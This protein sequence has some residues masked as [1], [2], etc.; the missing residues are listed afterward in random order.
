MLFKKRIKKNSSNHKTPPLLPQNIKSRKTNCYLCTG[1]KI[2]HKQ[3]T[4]NNSGVIIW[5]ESFLRLMGGI[6]VFT[7][8]GTMCSIVSTTAYEQN[9]R[10]TC[11]KLNENL[12]VELNHRYS[13]TQK[14][15]QALQI[16]TGRVTVF[17]QGKAFCL[18]HV[19]VVL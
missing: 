12:T 19:L 7:Y 11:N 1:N 2:K 4:K 9:K 14:Q 15:K 8:K 6:G 3:A 10:K 18:R 5:D 17:R 16:P 13:K